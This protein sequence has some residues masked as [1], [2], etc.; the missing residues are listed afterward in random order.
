MT[1]VALVEPTILLVLFALSLARPLRESRRR[2]RRDPREPLPGLLPRALLAFA[3]LVI[4]IIAETGRLPV[5]NPATHLELTMIHEAM[6]LEYSGP[7]LGL[8]E[9]ASG[10]RLGVLLALLAN[11]SSRGASRPGSRDRSLLARRRGDRGQG[12]VLRGGPGVGRGLPR[13]VASVRVPELLAGSFLL[14]ILAVTAY[15]FLPRPGR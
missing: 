6:T 15:S 1:V 2:S 13:Q 7:R 4:V 3:S 9:W 8:V 5:D 10:T 11:L 14:G 12:G